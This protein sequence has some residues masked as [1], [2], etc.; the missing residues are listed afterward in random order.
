[1]TPERRVLVVEDE[2]LV[3]TDHAEILQSAGF[4]VVGPAASID[5]AMSLIA[6]NHL[7]AAVLDVDLRGETSFAAAELLQ[8][9]GVP[10]VFLTGFENSDLPRDWQGARLLNKPVTP[11]AVLQA[12][13]DILVR[14]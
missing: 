5:T 2:W 11:N 9:N 4:T 12:V 8:R 3:A 1:M 10:F 13:E 14:T 6:E 7:D